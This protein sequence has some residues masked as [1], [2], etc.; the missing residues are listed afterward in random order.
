MNPTLFLT[1]LLTQHHTP[2]PPPTAPVAL[3]PGLGPW[4]HAISTTSPEAQKFFDQGLI[5]LYAFNRPEALRSFQKALELDPHAAMAQWGISMALGPYINMDGDASYQLKP[6]CE[7]AHAGLQIPNL[8]PSERPWLEAAATRC[9][10]FADPSKYIAA[11]RS[12]AAAH[13]DDPDAQTFYADAL[14]IRTRWA[15]YDSNGKPAEGQDEAE[16]VLEAVLRRLPD[17]P[18]ANHLYI[19]A[20]ESSPTPERGIPSAQRLMGI[21]PW[22][23]HIVHMPGHIWLATGEFQYAIDVNERAVQVDR[24]YFARTNM[25]GAYFGYY[26]H[27]IDFIVYA[28]TMLG[29]SAATAKAIKQMEDAARP[30]PSMADFVAPIVVMSR[31]RVQQWAALLAAPKPANGSPISLAYWHYGRAVAFAAQGK[32][33][34][35]SAE[36]SAFEMERKKLEPYRAAHFGSN[37][38]GF[39]LDLVSTILDARLESSVEKWRK[40]VAMQDALFYDEPPAWRYPLRESLGAA[41]LQSGNSSEAEVVFREG[42]RRSPHNGRMLFGLLESLKA[43]HK[44][45]AASW[46]EREFQSAWKSS[47]LTLRISDL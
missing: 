20:V 36:Q 24:E 11:M 17:H 34:E 7:A 29:R 13:P 15:W 46:V 47:D 31:A 12:L 22:A 10:D 44:T 26:L 1:L 39:V 30:E 9:P 45:E 21:V 28:S 2:A 8:N 41:L 14:L 37:K 42:L 6:S 43:Q 23:G 38:L 5:L 33:T 32:R 27:N 40:A 18:G 4:K 35:A 19:H 16:R 25:S 3:Y